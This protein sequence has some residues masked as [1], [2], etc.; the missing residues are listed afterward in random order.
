V[1]LHADALEEEAE[2]C[3]ADPVDFVY[4]HQ[5]DDVEDRSND[6]SPDPVGLT[7]RQV[8]L[9]QEEAFGGS[10]GRLLSAFLVTP[11]VIPLER[12]CV[13]LWHTACRHFT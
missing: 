3:A 4:P 5:S 13:R 8:T 2:I 12:L 10:A 9:C 1:Q 7:Q 6:G 11:H